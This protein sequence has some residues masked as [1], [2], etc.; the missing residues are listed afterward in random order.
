MLGISEVAF[1]KGEW[2]VVNVAAAFLSRLVA[3][4]SAEVSLEGTE[5]EEAKFALVL[6]RPGKSAVVN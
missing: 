3:V 2:K 1:R 4:D 5:E 6:V